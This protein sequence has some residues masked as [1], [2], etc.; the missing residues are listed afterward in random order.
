[1]SAVGKQALLVVI[2][3]CRI[4]LHSS[5]NCG[6]STVLVQNKIQERSRKEEQEEARTTHQAQHVRIRGTTLANKTKKT[7][8]VVL[9]CKRSIPTERSQPV[10]EVS[11]NFS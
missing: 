9:V 2:L 8:S 7:N 11:A 10:G 6:Q 4:L 1:M 5:L 3:Y